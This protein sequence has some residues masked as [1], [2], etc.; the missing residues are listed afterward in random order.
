M[1][2]SATR[3]RVRPFTRRTVTAQSAGEL[4]VPHSSPGSACDGLTSESSKAHL[5]GSD[6]PRKECA[7]SVLTAAPSSLSN[8][9]TPWTSSTSRHAVWMTPNGCRRRIT[10]ARAVSSGGSS[11]PTISPST[12]KLGT[13]NDR[14]A[15]LQV[16][17]TGHKHHA[18]SIV[19]A[20][21]PFTKTLALYSALRHAAVCANVT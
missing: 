18:T 16:E 11:W 21:P 7:V 1:A 4:Q 9:M 8:T 10:R 6:Q 12:A 19:R 5:L 20:G 17:R 14:D 13:N 15:Q 3:Q 2:R